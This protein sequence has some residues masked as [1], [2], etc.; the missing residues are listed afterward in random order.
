MKGDD[1]DDPAKIP[2][3]FIKIY[4]EMMGKRMVERDHVNS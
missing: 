3:A 1:I 4:T 2:D